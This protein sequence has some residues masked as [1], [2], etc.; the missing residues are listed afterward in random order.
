[1]L[2]VPCS[3]CGVTGWLPAPCSCS[4]R[5]GLS[6]LQS[7]PSTDG[8]Q[9]IYYFLEFHLKASCRA[10]RFWKREARC[11]TLPTEQPKE[12]SEIS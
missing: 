4:R 9:V 7:V 8:R 6:S 12:R 10:S 1:M 11:A 2:S 3:L 5:A